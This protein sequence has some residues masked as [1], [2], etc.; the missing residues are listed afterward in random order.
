MIEPWITPFS[1]VVYRLFH[2]EEC[3]LALDLECAL[4]ESGKKA[5]DGNA[6]IP[7]RLLKRS[8]G[9]VGALALRHA[10][11]FLAL[12]YLL[13]LGFKRRRPVPLNLLRLGRAV[14]RRLGP[15]AKLNA[16]R[17]RCVWEKV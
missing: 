9:R 10:D 6:A 17:I 8:R 7:Y 12:A 5:F 2:H 3:R 4:N 15:I 16:T 13:S 11:P 14:E 1:F